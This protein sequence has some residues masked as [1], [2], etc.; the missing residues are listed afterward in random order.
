VC[1][2]GVAA[3]DLA[4]W[5]LIPY[6]AQWPEFYSY[7]RAAFD[8]TDDSWNPAGGGAP[9]DARLPYGKMINSIYLLTYA[10]R[11]EYLPQFHSRED[12]M[13]AANGA[14]NAFHDD[15]EYQFR[16]R[17][18][19]LS[20][21]AIESG[22]RTEMYCPVF[23]VGVYVD[24]PARRASVMVHEGWHHWQYKY[25]WQSHHEF[26]GAI[27]GGQEGDKFYFH[28]TGAFDFGQLH[29]ID[30]GANPIKF[31]SPYQ[32]EAEFLAD[33][34]EYSFGWIPIAVTDSAKAF[35]NDILANRFQNATSYRIGQPRPF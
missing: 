3:V 32:V 16:N 9:D 29:T 15:Y 10:I 34:A 5:R 18:D 17:N 30:L 35:G 31:H 4:V 25:N 11:N 20:A 24:D 13:L 1:I 21:K 2:D 26:G 14:D 22:S 7:A 12:Y 23:N 33:L 6:Q 19:G 8:L 27:T 28:G